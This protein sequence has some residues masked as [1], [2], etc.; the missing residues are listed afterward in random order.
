MS[1]TA[2]SSTGATAVARTMSPAVAASAGA[3]KL[4]PTPT[5]AVSY[6]P[7]VPNAIGQLALT[8]SASADNDGDDTGSDGNDHD[9]DDAPASSKPIAVST[10]EDGTY[11]IGMAA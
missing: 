9:A 2:L 1:I 5:V 11:S 7:A 4:G 8:A 3:T 6:G 10:A